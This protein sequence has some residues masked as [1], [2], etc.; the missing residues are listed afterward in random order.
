MYEGKFSNEET[1]NFYDKLVSTN[2]PICDGATEL[3]LLISIR[4][5]TARTI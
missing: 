5:L 3:R 1:Q 2:E 4:L